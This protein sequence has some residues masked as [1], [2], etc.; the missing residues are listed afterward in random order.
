[1]FG[2]SIQ[3]CLLRS[4]FLEIPNI[5]NED[6]LDGILACAKIIGKIFK[7]KLECLYE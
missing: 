5:F 3:C 7:K 2:I 6:Y 1:M 4:N